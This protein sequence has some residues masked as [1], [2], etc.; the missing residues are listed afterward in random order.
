MGDIWKTAIS[1]S[2]NKFLGKVITF[3]PNLLA[4]ITILVVGFLIA[5]VVKKLLSRFLKAIQFDRLSERW[6]FAHILS[7][8]GM[9]YPPSSLISRFFC[10]MIVIITLILGVNALEVAVTQNLITHFFNYLPHLFAAFFILVIGYLIA[11][12]L[13]QAALIAA[14]NAQIESARLLS[15]TVRWFIVILS[16]TMAIYHLGI[17]G[18][19]IVIAFSITFGGIVLA[20][21]IAFGWGGRDLAKDFLEKL[22]KRGGNQGGPDSISHI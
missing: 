4:M 6:G 20:L 2:F 3:L 15:R 14:V 12:F 21:A 5:W 8:G 19:V 17:A 13:S 11:V 10:W 9:T 1:D 18:E 7:K 22:R 16:L